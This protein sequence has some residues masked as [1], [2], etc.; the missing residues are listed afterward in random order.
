MTDMKEY[1]EKNG[2]PEEFFIISGT[3]GSAA[4]VVQ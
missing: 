3:D 2:L 1:F 4:V